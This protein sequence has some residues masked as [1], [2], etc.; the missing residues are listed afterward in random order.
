MSNDPRVT[1]FGKFIRRWS[2]DELPQLINIIKGEMSLVGPRPHE[3][4]EVAKYQTRHHK[5]LNIKPGLTGLGQVAGRSQLTF[6]EEFKLD[7]FYVENWTLGQD[8]V[9]LAKT[10]I[11]VLQRKAAV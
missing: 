8:M 9:I 1:K 6:E 2:L 11:V 7:T 3:P 10:I 4:A 5:L